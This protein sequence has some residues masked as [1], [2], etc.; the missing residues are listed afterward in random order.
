MPQAGPTESGPTLA[1]AYSLATLGGRQIKSGAPAGGFDVTAWNSATHS[2]L[3]SLS[4]F[5]TRRDSQ[6]TEQREQR[7]AQ[8]PHNHFDGVAHGGIFFNNTASRPGRFVI[9]SG[10]TFIH[11][12]RY[13]HTQLF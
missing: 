5:A 1:L 9:F 6:L 4:A 2:Q 10:I 7:P 12:G 11:T 13:P 8:P 3:A